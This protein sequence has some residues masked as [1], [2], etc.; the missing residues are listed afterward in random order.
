MFWFTF[1]VILNRLYPVSRR[2]LWRMLILSMANYLLDPGPTCWMCLFSTLGP[3]SKMDMLVWKEG[4]FDSIFRNRIIRSK[5]FLRAFIYLLFLSFSHITGSLHWWGALEMNHAWCSLLR[6]QRKGPDRGTRRQTWRTGFL[7]GLRLSTWYLWSNPKGIWQQYSVLRL[8]GQEK[9]SW[10]RVGPGP[11]CWCQGGHLWHLGGPGWLLGHQPEAETASVPLN[12][13]WEKKHREGIFLIN[14]WWI[15]W[16]LLLFKMIQYKNKHQKEWPS[17]KRVIRRQQVHKA[18]AHPA[19]FIHCLKRTASE[20]L[21]RMILG[22]L[23][24][25]NVDTSALQ[26]L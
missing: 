10:F 22:Q 5:A 11:C 7:Q 6:R 4:T 3:T 17:H 16:K 18:P 13:S 1:T 20:C 8:P 19:L 12:P 15:I 26:C 25:S 21:I 9:L 2:R 14:W 23:N 24:Y